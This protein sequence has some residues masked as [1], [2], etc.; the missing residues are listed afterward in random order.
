MKR[1]LLLILITTFAITSQAQNNSQQIEAMM[2]KRVL[3]CDDIW[4]NAYYLIPELYQ[5]N[6]INLLDS[7]LQYIELRCRVNDDLINFKVLKQ[8]AQGSFNEDIYKDRY[9]TRTLERY[10]KTINNLKT[11]RSGVSRPLPYSYLPT[12]LSQTSDTF[13]HFLQ[14]TAITLHDG[15]S[16]PALEQWLID[17]YANP[18][19]SLLSRLKDSTFSSTIIQKDY[20]LQNYHAN[21][22]AGMIFSASAGAWIPNG[23]IALLGTHPYINVHMGGRGRKFMAGITVGAKF[24]KSPNHYSVL[25]KDSLH[26]SNSFVGY[27]AGFDMGYSLMETNK[28]EFD[29]IGGIGYDGLTT[30]SIEHDDDTKD[31]SQTIHSLNLN[32]GLGYK[33]WFKGG[34]FI[35]LDAKYNFLFYNNKGGTSLS[36]NVLTVGVTLGFINRGN[37][38]YGHPYYLN[39]YY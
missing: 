15:N 36:G 20:A 27:Y 34:G 37:Q 25:R 30:L 9:I 16:R 12:L 18:S 22:R 1:L 35:G 3:R 39:N 11:I 7:L 38:R 6:D 23:D 5:K 2:T 32:A 24:I 21:E 13:N 26:S 4:Y 31:I 8:I 10:Q 28:S 29:V 17:Y 14:Q 33:Y 19:D